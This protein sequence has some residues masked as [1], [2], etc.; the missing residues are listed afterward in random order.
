KVVAKYTNNEKIE[1]IIFKRQVVNNPETLLVSVDSVHGKTEPFYLVELKVFKDKKTLL[2]A[3][4]YI[5]HE[6]TVVQT[7]HGKHDLLI[8]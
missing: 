3:M 5:M 8:D 6:F 1:H 7:T 4:K 2:S